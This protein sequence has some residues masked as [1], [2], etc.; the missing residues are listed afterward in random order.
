MCLYTSTYVHTGTKTEVKLWRQFSDLDFYIG[1]GN[2]MQVLFSSLCGKH[3]AY[4]PS[5]SLINI[6]VC[7][8]LSPHTL[9]TV[10]TVEDPEVDEITSLPSNES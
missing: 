3:F 5:L 10:L 4:W 7:E 6:L 8:S 9:G 2:W 1:A